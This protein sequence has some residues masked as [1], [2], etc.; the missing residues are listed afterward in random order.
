VIHRKTG[1]YTSLA[2]LVMMLAGAARAELGGSV[3]T[4]QADQA[5]MKA[6]VRPG[7]SGPGYSVH[8]MQTPSGITVRE[9]A[10]TSGN[11]FAVTWQGPFMPDLKQLLG[12]YFSNYVGAARKRHGGLHHLT[13]A[14]KNLVVHSQGHMRA[15]SGIA[16]LPAKLPTGV[17]PADLQ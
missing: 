4:V 9:Y 5:R 8:V 14:D 17:K 1:L 3:A 15:F 12:P 11:V 10:D 6:A 7:T 16:Y 2:L 13:V